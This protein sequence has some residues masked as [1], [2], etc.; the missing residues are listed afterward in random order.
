MPGSKMM[1]QD[2]LAYIDKRY[3]HLRKLTQTLKRKINDLEDIMRQENDDRNAEQIQQLI[4]DI[5]REK[6]MIRDEAHIIRGELT[7]AMYNEDLR[8]GTV[9][10]SYC[11]AQFVYTASPCIVMDYI[12]KGNNSQKE[13]ESTITTESHGLRL[14]S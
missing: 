3:D 8:L 12:Y 2:R 6:Q 7:Q 5:K 14:K 9:S 4:E 11:K 1:F 13:C 10:Q